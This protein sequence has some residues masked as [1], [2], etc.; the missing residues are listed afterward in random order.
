MK[1]IPGYL[2]MFFGAVLIFIAALIIKNNF[3]E[4]AEAGAASDSLLTG[5]IE[6]MPGRV[7]EPELS[8]DMPIVD[9]DGRSF[10]GTVEI[11]SYSKRVEQ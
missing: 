2:Y 6:Q 4:N 3:D 11:P 9:V 10:I 5:V 1:K 8:G 7:I